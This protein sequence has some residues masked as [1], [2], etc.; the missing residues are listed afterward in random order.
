MAR[1]HNT[2]TRRLVHNL[3]RTYRELGNSGNPGVAN[4][5]RNEVAALGGG[6]YRPRYGN[7]RKMM[8][9][10]KLRLRRSDRRQRN[11]QPLELE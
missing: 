1:T 11:D 4:Q 3:D 7:H 8:A 10:Q 2:S 5:I 9:E 6:Q